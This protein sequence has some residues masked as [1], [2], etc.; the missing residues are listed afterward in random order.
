[1]V[2]KEKNK[3]PGKRDFL[4]LALCIF[5]ILFF[6]LYAGPFLEPY[7]GLKPIAQEIDRR[8]INANMYF[9]TEVEEFSEAQVLM[10][11][12]RKY[13]VRS[14]TPVNVQSP[15]SAPLSSTP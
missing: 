1:L 3:G 4:F 13:P 8:D 10:T 12:M 9:Y 6:I 14:K 7:L 5:F 11:N 15:S 2:L